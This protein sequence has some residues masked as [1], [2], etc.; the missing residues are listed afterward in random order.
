MMETTEE[1]VPHAGTTLHWALIGLLAGPTLR[2]LG[3]VVRW[4]V[5]LPLGVWRPVIRPPVRV[6]GR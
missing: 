3:Q 5:L 6:V 1:A 2:G 4:L